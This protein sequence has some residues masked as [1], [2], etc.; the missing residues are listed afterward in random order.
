[1]KGLSVGTSLLG[2]VFALSGAAAYLLADDP[3]W[4][5][6][7]NL[8]LG[9]VLI[10]GSVAFVTI[11]KDHKL[12]PTGRTVTLKTDDEKTPVIKVPIRSIMPSSL[13]L[14]VTTWPP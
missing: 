13:V 3:G 4:L 7:V 8:G 5:P 2:A 6:L 11:P 10:A 14:R 12:P 9:V 1:M